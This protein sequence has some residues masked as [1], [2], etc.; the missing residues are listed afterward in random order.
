MKKESIVAIDYTT[1]KGLAKTWAETLV[2]MADLPCDTY[3]QEAWWA[4]L[5]GKAQTELKSVLSEREALVRPL[6][7]DKRLVDEAFKEATVPVE[8]VKDLCK[9]KLAALQTSRLALKSATLDAAQQAAASGNVEGCMAAI[10]S[11]TED[12]TVEG[13]ATRWMWTQEIVD[14]SLVPR[15]FLTVDHRAI[16]AYAKLY[17]RMETIDPIPGIE[18]TRTARISAR[19]K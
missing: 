1:L 8:A 9:A 10:E 14:A 13:A 11:V 3:E 16:Q 6:L 19:S 7:R 12:R 4:A 17:G 18:F 2:E 5:L 15:E